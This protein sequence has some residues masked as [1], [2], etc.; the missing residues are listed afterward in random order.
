MFMILMG[1]FNQSKMS[2]DDEIIV[3]FYHADKTRS[4]QAGAMSELK[5]SVRK[6]SRASLMPAIS[7]NV[8][9]KERLFWQTDCKRCPAIRF[10][11]NL[12]P[13]SMGL[14]DL[15]GDG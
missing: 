2:I 7:L 6:A 15:P 13:A 11:L 8:N 10:A 1:G 9:L 14:D 5:Q 12:D 3:E 4:S